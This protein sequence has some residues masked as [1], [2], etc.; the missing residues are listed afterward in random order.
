MLSVRPLLIHHLLL[1]HKLLY[2]VRALRMHAPTGKGPLSMIDHPPLH[3][4]SGTRKKHERAIRTVC[5]ECSVGC[6]II[7]YVDDNRIVD[8]TGDERHP[9]SSGRL[10]S[11][12]IAFVQGVENPLRVTAPLYRESTQDTFTPVS[13]WDKA[14]DL[15][16]DRLKRARERHGPECL[17]IACD[18]HAGLDF[19]LGARRFARLWGTSLVFDV[20]E[21]PS[22][23][24]LPSHLHSPTVSCTEWIRSR[25]LFLVESDLAE[26]HPVA[27]RWVAEAQDRGAK[28]VVADS[29]FTSS[30]AKADASIAI[31]PGG[32]NLLGAALSRI[33]LDKGKFRKDLLKE[34][35]RDHSAWQASFSNL[36]AVD[37]ENVLGVS[38]RELE[39]LQ[40]LLTSEERV[41]VITGPSLAYRPG[42]GIWLAMA[43]GLG[44]TRQPGGGWYS[45]DTGQP[46]FQPDDSGEDRHPSV[47]WS[48]GDHSSLAQTVIE[49]AS[50]GRR[51]PVRA[52]ITTGNSLGGFLAPFSSCAEELEVLAHFG[53]FANPTLNLSHVVFPS[54]VWAERDGLFF[55]N[56]RVIHWARK[57][58]E[59]N[60]NCR[61][62]LDFLIG[63]AERFGWASSEN[64][65]EPEDQRS[66]GDWLLGSSPM[67]RGCSVDLLLEAHHKG[68]LVRWPFPEGRL[69]RRDPPFFLTADGK[70][71]PE[72]IPS[73]WE[74][75]T[76]SERF[77]L[78]F[79]STGT[80]ASDLIGSCPW[81]TELESDAIHIHPDT[82]GALRIEN[83]AKIIVECA[84]GEIE[85]Y[86]RLTRAVPTGM[87]AGTQRFHSPQVL[88]RTPDQT[89]EEALAILTEL[90]R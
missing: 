28:V 20:R 6:G 40:A 21:R 48:A 23:N 71:D 22:G 27:W 76:G 8:V 56:D 5:Q 68:D 7:A 59:P 79:L 78:L 38:L 51:A 31:M 33:A 65:T 90:L 19:S 29:R 17:A 67:T 86:A 74:V 60:E 12:G 45:V 34:A 10:C 47:Q 11:R 89:S 84:T 73:Q 58:V 49:E 85:A 25:C 44:W 42:H 46:S 88:V 18:A 37:L 54:A 69:V 15:L 83:G 32:G 75:P 64:D 80:P 87:L 1:A 72:P 9:I 41:T 82:A 30:M 39:D 53:S 35:F 52:L 61:S 3:R 57:I 63:L 26:T 14:L 50:A 81:I 36:E 43:T 16:A 77:P 2:G 13:D 62:G 55:S 70:I 66:F 4:I 24:G